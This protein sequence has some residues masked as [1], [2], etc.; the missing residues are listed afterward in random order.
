VLPS[1]HEPQGIVVAEAMAAGAPVL[2]A[3]VGGVPETV[4]DGGNGLLFR[5]GDVTSLSQSL[6]LLLE[7]PEAAQTRAVQASKD[8]EAY[9]WTRITDLY[10]DCYEVALS[11]A[12]AGTASA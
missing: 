9:D 4:K 3:R 6:A 8:V 2:A 7:N 12:R 5:G 11:N 10:E 1:R